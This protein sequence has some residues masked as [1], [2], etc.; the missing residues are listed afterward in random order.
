MTQAYVKM[1]MPQLA[2]DSLRVLERNYP[3]SPELPKL[4]ALVKGAG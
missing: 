2:A 1:D 4:N 3:Q